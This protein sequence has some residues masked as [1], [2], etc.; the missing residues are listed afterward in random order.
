MVK[1]WKIQEIEWAYNKFE[2]LSKYYSKDYLNQVLLREKY[3]TKI[4]LQ[5]TESKKY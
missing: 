3:L 2:R 4:W 5:F 1:Q